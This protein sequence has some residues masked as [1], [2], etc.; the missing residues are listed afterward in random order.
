[1]LVLASLVPASAFAQSVTIAVDTAL[2]NEAGGTATFTMTLLGE[3]TLPVTANLGFSGTATGGGVDYTT[4]GT[5]ITIPVGFNSGTVTVTSIQDVDPEPD[6]TIVVTI[7]SV[8]YAEVGNPN[9]ATSTIVDNTTGV[10]SEIDD[11]LPTGVRLEQNYP[12][13]FNPITSISYSLSGVQHVRL[14]VSDLLG[15]QIAV[16]VD[17]LQAVGN[18]QV[19]FRAADLPSAV[20]IYRLE[21]GSTVRTKQMILLQ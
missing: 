19:T 10:A 1:M 17:E 12:N 2:I 9:Q 11:T 4:S 20:Y 16:L 15:R 6:E 7:L 21:A 14:T 13:P 3:A 18:H 5:S 8:I